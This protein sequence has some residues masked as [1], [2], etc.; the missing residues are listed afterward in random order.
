DNT[1]DRTG[2]AVLLES[3]GSY[4]LMDTA[5]EENGN[6]VVSYLKKIGVKNLDV[7]IS[8]THADHR[9]ALSEVLANFNIGTVYLPDQSIGKD[10]VNDATGI[11]QEQIYNNLTSACDDEGAKIVYLKKGSTFTVGAVS[12]E[13][14]GPVG[15]YKMSQF[16]G[17]KSGHY[18][19]DYSLTTMFTCNGKKFLTTGDIEKEEEKALVNAY[20]SKLKADIIKLPHHGLT[21]TSNTEAFI[22][23]VKPTYAFAENSDYISPTK[24]TK[25]IDG[26]SR[27]ISVS[28]AY[29]TID[30][31]GKYGLTYLV[32]NEGYTAIFDCTSSKIN[33]YVDKNN[34]G[35]ADSKEL[36]TGWVS[37]CGTTQKKYNDYTGK[38]Y[39]YISNGKIL[40]GVQK[41]DKKYY[42]LGEGGIRE[43]GVIQSNGSF[44]GYRTYGKKLRYYNSDASMAVGFVKISGNTFYF[45]KNGYKVVGDKNWKLVTISGKKYALNASGVVYNNK[46]KG[47]WLT[48]NKAKTKQKIRYFNKKGVMATGWLTVSGS[49]YYMNPS[50]GL[51][52]YGV[53][54]VGDKAYYFNDSGKL[55]KKATITIGKVKVKTNSNGQ[56]T[57][58]L[59]SKVSGIK[60]SAKSKKVNI[61]WKKIKKNADGYIVYRATSKNGTYKAVKTITSAKTVKYT[62]TS[63]KKGTKYYYKVCAYKTIQSTKVKGAYSSIKS[64]KAK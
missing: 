30:R 22:D 33:M 64:V 26:K 27:T 47:G 19:N 63:V 60:V 2:D 61:S 16:S 11:T 12:A 1:E 6:D 35:V 49:K 55:K 54:N 17:H 8:H 43:T 28:K 44:S 48:Y 37:V 41:I 9:G 53:V 32:G 29:T 38:N 62:D 46:G 4:L 36:K 21:T 39:F 20:G 14:L 5:A 51:R 34:N 40:K 18:L 25:K 23:A 57:S 50:T 3:N 45:D 10:Y 15:S 24:L 59:P 58:P 56:I 31:V 52:S 13:V 7:Y 42:Y